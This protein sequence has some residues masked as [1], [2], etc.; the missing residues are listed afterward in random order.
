MDLSQY[1]FPQRLEV[2]SVNTLQLGEK[3]GEKEENKRG[4]G[5]GPNPQQGEPSPTP[6]GGEKEEHHM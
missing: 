4:A 3:Q 6:T 2:T 1:G 5:A